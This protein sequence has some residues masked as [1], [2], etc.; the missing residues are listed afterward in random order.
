M[1]AIIVLK[2]HIKRKKKA[3]QIYFFIKT[4]T[5]Q[6]VYIWQTREEN[7]LYLPVFSGIISSSIRNK[8]FKCSLPVNTTGAFYFFAFY[9]IRHF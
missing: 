7:L 6:A 8:P 5:G 1:G 4:E 3:R 2:R 9:P